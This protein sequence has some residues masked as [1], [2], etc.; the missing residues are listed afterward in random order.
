MVYYTLATG[1]DANPK[2]SEYTNQDLQPARQT[3]KP[4]SEK[5]MN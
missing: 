5:Q 3:S 1:P 4:N 2:R